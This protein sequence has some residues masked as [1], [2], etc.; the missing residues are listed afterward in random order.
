MGAQV[1]NR[2]RLFNRKDRNRSQSVR[3]QSKVKLW[4]M[5]GA[6]WTGLSAGGD[7]CTLSG[8]IDSLRVLKRRRVELISGP[9]FDLRALSRASV[10]RRS[11]PLLWIPRW[12]FRSKEKGRLFSLQ[13]TLRGVQDSGSGRGHSGQRVDIDRKRPVEMWW[14][15]CRNRIPSFGETD[16]SI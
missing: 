2:V 12:L 1:T 9:P 8:H 15:T 14:H 6:V 11:L 4:Y 10:H 7:G 3:S 13:F 5:M 16:E